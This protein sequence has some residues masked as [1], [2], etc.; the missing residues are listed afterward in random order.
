MIEYLVD[1]I[2]EERVES[3]RGQQKP[4]GRRQKMSRYPIRR[5][6]KLSREEHEWTPKILK[7]L[8]LKNT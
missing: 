5:R 2:L 8:T 4:R 3:S 1:E 7:P 6:G